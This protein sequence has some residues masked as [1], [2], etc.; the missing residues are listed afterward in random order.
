MNRARLFAVIRKETRALL[1]D[2]RARI[3]LVGPPVIQLLIFAFAS[4]VAITDVRLG[5]LDHDGGRASRSVIEHVA[6][7]PLVTAIVPIRSEAEI[8]T[9]IQRQSVLAV[10][11]FPPGFTRNRLAGEGTAV[12]IVYDGRRTNAAPRQI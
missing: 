8:A 11:R 12:D 3:L 6:A 1:R 7:S 10:L 4:T 9:A 2:P 5:V